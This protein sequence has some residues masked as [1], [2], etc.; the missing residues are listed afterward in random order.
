[1]KGVTVERRGLCYKF[2]S[3]SVCTGYPMIVAYISGAA[4]VLAEKQA[5]EVVVQSA[6]NVLRQVY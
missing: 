1:M 6:L 3:L 5:D 4:A 2:R